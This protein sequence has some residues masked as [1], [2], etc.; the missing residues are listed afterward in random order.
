MFVKFP[1]IALVA[2]VITMV[3]GPWAAAQ[4]AQPAAATHK[5]YESAPQ[6]S[7]PGPNG[8]LAPRL[9]N[10]GT[11]T[12][13]VSTTKPAAQRFINQGLNLAYAFNHAEARRAFREAARLDPD[14]GHRLLGP[15]AGARPEHQR[16]HGAQR[17]AARL[18]A[19]SEGAVAQG[20]GDAA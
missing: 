17:G 20:Q 8:E 18:R 1:R 13:P 3:S 14:P 4:V 6:A 11:H 10:L 12:F 19:D 7:Q 2:G 5:H 9:Q 15:G 16:G